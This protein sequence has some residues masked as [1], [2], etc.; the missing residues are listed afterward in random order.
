[1]KGTSAFLVLDLIASVAAYKATTTVS[2]FASSLYRACRP[3]RAD[4]KLTKVS[5][6][7]TMM[8]RRVRADVAPAL[9]FSPG[10]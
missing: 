9:V 1:M 4:F 6:R 3:M 2:S 7:G 5:H 10:R 8:V